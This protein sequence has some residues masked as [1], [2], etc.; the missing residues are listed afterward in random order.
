MG[1]DTQAGSV[2]RPPETGSNHRGAVHADPHTGEVFVCDTVA[3]R[4]L[5][6]DRHGVFRYEIPGGPGF[7]APRDVTVDPEGY[8]LTIAMHRGGT[9]ILRLDFDGR[10]IE[11]IFLTGLPDGSAA[12]DLI[13]LAQSSSGDRLYALDSSNMRL[14]IAARDG[15]II[16]SIDLA[17]DLEEEESFEQVLGHVDVYGETI[18]VAIPTTGR[19]HLFDLAGN[20]RGT[21]GLKGTS[22]CRT[23]FPVTAAMGADGDLLILD[24]QRALVMKWDPGTNECLGEYSGFGNAPGALYRPI[25]LA[26]GPGGQLYVSQGFEGRVQVFEGFAPADGVQ[27]LDRNEDPDGG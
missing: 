27:T 20:E 22:P 23:G 26:L 21:V 19:V 6:F 2:C 25:D 7:R 8:I 14:W 11:T 13:S 9:D 16:G 24:N 3:H 18:L 15:A 17:E 1:H 4:I 10:F 12:P 5:I